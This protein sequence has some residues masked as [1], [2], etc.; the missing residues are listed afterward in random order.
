MTTGSGDRSRA[1]H[2]S[3]VTQR[4]NTKGHFLA[5]YEALRRTRTVDPLLTMESLRQPVAPGRNGFGLFSA[6]LRSV[7]L[8]MI[9]TGCNHGAPQRLH[10][11][12]A[13]LATRRSLYAGNVPGASEEAR[14]VKIM[15]AN[16]IAGAD[17]DDGDFQLMIVTSDDR[18][19]VVAPSP[20]AMT[21]LVALARADTVLVWDPADRRLIAANLRG[22]MPWTE[23]P[24]TPGT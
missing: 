19:F 9:A 7:D 11:S 21:A 1:S 16:W 12:L 8:P 10:P 24:A 18:Q 3:G 2:G 15:N 17:G 5:F 14:R 20:A 4:G 23:G 22:T 13:K 6:L